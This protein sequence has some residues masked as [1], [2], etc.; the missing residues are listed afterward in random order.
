MPA[1]SS[2]PQS[3]QKRCPA[4][5]SFPQRWHFMAWSPPPGVDRS[6]YSPTPARVEAGLPPCELRS[7]S[8]RMVATDED[9]R[10]PARHGWGG[11]WTSRTGSAGS[12]PPPAQ[13]EPSATETPI[14][15]PPTRRRILNGPSSRALPRRIV[16]G[17]IW[18]LISAATESEFGIA[19]IGIGVLTGFAVVFAARGSARCPAPGDRRVRAPCWVSCGGSTTPS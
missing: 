7:N 15:P 11:S 12:P 13:L 1:A 8:R 9:G 17:I 6:A 3:P 14:L 2:L 10:T 5:F 19:A 18:G 16:G 4:G